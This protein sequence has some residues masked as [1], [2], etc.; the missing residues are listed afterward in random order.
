[1]R[2]IRDRPAVG[3][4]TGPAI[5]LFSRLGRAFFRS[6]ATLVGFLTLFAV[7]LRFAGVGV[8][9]RLA[10]TCRFA[11]C[12]PRVSSSR[13]LSTREQLAAASGVWPREPAVPCDLSVPLKLLRTGPNEF[14]S[15]DCLELSVL[16]RDSF[17]GLWS[18]LLEPIRP[19]A[20]RALPRRTCRVSPR[21]RAC[22]SAY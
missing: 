17:S 5:G 13:S 15:H 12:P 14:T 6:P 2:V 4:R 1:M 3:A 9:Q 20:F 21:H 7:L 10:P 11:F 16:S 22:P 19:W 8:F 18:P